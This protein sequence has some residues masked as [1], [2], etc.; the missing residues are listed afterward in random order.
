MSFEKSKA[1]STSHTEEEV[2]QEDLKQEEDTSTDTGQSEE[3]ETDSEEDTSTNE[4]DDDGSQDQSDTEEPEEG[5]AEYWKQK[6]EQ[7]EA[8]KSNYQ[9][10]LLSAKASK[11]AEKGIASVSSSDTPADEQAVVRVLEKQNERKALRDVINP[12]STLYIPEL[13]DDSQYQE[14]V[15]YLP[16]NIDKSSVESIHKALKLATKYWKEEHGIV[17]KKP[18]SKK[19]AD[20]AATRSGTASGVAPTT[21]TAKS[22]RKIIKKTPSVKDWYN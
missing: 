13:V 20:V 12:K 5:S 6:F 21:D 8:D 9:Q 16:M 3:N 1:Q 17:D 18:A 15:S 19:S 2:K 11:R 10:G 14:I 7:A 22:E 4:G